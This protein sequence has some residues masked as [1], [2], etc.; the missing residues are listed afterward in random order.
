[1]AMPRFWI[2]PEPAL[3]Q[4]CEQLGVELEARTGH[5][6]AQRVTIAFQQNYYRDNNEFV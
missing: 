5:K 6:A 1:M 2:S 3:V 4:A